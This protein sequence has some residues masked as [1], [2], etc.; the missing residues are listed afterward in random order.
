MLCEFKYKD[1]RVCGKE[2]CDNMRHGKKK[3]SVK[4]ENPSLSKEKPNEIEELKKFFLENITK[5]QEENSKLKDRVSKLEEKKKKTTEEKYHTCSAELSGC[6]GLKFKG[7]PKF[8]DEEN[9]PVCANC[10]TKLNN[11]A[12]G[13]DCSYCGK[14]IDYNAKVFDGLC[15]DCHRSKSKKKTV[16]DDTMGVQVKEKTK[17]TKVS[18]TQSVSTISIEELQANT[19]TVSEQLENLRDIMGEEKKKSK[20]KTII[21]SF[22]EK[23]QRLMKR[24]KYLTIKENKQFNVDFVKIQDDIEKTGELEKYQDILDEIENTYNQRVKDKYYN[25]DN[26]DE[27]DE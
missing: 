20:K 9:K 24:A 18:N 19:A 2:E 13:K 1:G 8:F 4:K 11:L 10:R 14:H 6:K 26:E 25:E 23:L 27:E 17:K 5:L 12:K 21:P 16:F 7:E 3:V 22:N 15:Y